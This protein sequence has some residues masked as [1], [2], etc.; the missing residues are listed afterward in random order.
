MSFLLEDDYPGAGRPQPAAWSQ[1]SQPEPDWAGQDEDPAYYE[2]AYAD[3]AYADPGYAE[4]G[5]YE[6]DGYYQGPPYYQDPPDVPGDDFPGQ[7]EPDAYLD[8][9]ADDY[10]ET[11]AAAGISDG[12][13]SPGRPRGRRHRGGRRR[14]FGTGVQRMAGLLV[15]AASVAG[16]VLL[17]PSILTA[18]KNRPLTGVVSR[19]S[20]ASL[21]F[22]VAG[23]VGK[24]VVRLGQVVRKGEVLAREAA[25]G[26]L[27]PVRTDRAAI[28]ADKADLAALTA[29]AAPPAS[30]AAA[31]AQ[32]AKDQ[33]QRAADQAAMVIKAPRPGTVIA[34]FGQA[35]ATVT[36][37]G[38]RSAAAA[39][40]PAGS[41]AS[42]RAGG[43]ALPVLAL[44]ISGEV[45]VKVSIPARSTAKVRVGDTVALAIPADRLTGVSG[46]ITRLTRQ[47]GGELRA[48]VQVSRTSITPL[49]GMTAEVLLGA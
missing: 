5:Y 27:G 13:P 44:R 31:R 37:A 32:L 40:R 29:A 43:M 14:R 33:T 23:R 4:P 24:I 41:L 38:L 6:P 1:R 10:A 46:T 25:P 8:A 11:G 3:P 9:V 45:L 30:V 49:A 42:L 19:S 36:S 16:V 12:P 39:A 21:N 48:V 18:A 47:P 20:L 35:G 34:V 28:A 17:A 2:P 7:P 15:A 22:G 26:G